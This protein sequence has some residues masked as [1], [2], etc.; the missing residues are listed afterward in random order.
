ML[1]KKL[2]R[3]CIDSSRAVVYRWNKSWNQFDEKNWSHDYVVCPAA[4]DIWWSTLSH[5]P[6][7]CPLALEH[8]VLNQDK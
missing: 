7:W 4:L 3:R 1:S 8:V 5:P 2:C 6:E